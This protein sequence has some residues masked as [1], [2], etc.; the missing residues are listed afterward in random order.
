M[1]VE[2]L[3]E[4]SVSHGGKRAYHPERCGFDTENP[5]QKTI[6]LPLNTVKMYANIV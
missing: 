6:N 2:G 3:G 5:I 4:L 1:K